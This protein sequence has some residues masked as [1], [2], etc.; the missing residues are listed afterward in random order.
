MTAA[1]YAEQYGDPTEAKRWRVFR[2]EIGTFNGRTTWNRSLAV[3]PD[4]GLDA[5][6][7][8]FQRHH[9]VIVLTAE[10]CGSLYDFNAARRETEA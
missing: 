2:F 4:I 7:Q 9:G 10:D 1:E 8:Q 6:V 5:A 3:D